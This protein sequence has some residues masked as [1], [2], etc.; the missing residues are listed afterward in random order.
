LTE[1]DLALPRNVAKRRHTGP[2]GLLGRYEGSADLVRG[3]ESSPLE[4]FSTD[5][6]ELVY[7]SGRKAWL[8]AF[9]DVRSKLVAGWVIGPARNRD[10]A[11]RSLKRL[12][13]SLNRLGITPV[14]RTLHH[15]KDSVY[16]SY[17]WLGKLLLDL[18]ML[19]SFSENG[20]RHG[21]GSS[22]S[23]LGRSM[24]ALRG[25]LTRRLSPTSLPLWTSTTT[26]TTTSAGTRRSATPPRWGIYSGRT[27]RALAEISP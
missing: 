27:S 12:V 5:F 21:R 8:M 6:T 23:G 3:R 17:A 11:L 19:V 15:D 9:V 18:G 14:G 26:V 22:L 7:G 10:L 1:Q 16:T 4:A 20:A 13:K 24:S 2:A 25:S